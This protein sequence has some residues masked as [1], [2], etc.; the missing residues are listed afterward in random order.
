MILSRFKNIRGFKV[1]KLALIL[2]LNFIFFQVSFGQ[3]RKNVDRTE[4]TI[5][6][7]I[8]TFTRGFN[9]YTPIALVAEI[10]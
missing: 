1:K 7:K 3:G 9:E 8:V 4:L 5:C 10:T 2:M 6:L